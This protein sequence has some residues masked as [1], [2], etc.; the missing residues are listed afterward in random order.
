MLKLSAQCSEVSK[1]EFKARVQSL[2]LARS[3]EQIAMTLPS[4]ELYA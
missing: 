1:L 3:F 2:R 4:D